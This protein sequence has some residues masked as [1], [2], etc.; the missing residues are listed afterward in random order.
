MHDDIYKLEGM[1]MI[2]E[3]K[4]AEFIL[5]NEKICKQ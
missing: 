2:P 1:V 3:D 5:M 4:K